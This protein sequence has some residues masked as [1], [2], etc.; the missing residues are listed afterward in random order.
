MRIVGIDPSSTLSGVALCDDQRL[1]DTWVWQ[2][3]A[4]ASPPQNLADYYHWLVRLLLTGQTEPTDSH[5]MKRIADM[6]VVESLS[7]ERNAKVTRIVSHYQAI[8]VLAAKNAGLV[9]IETRA[10]TAR[11][12]V[13]GNGNMPKE[14]VHKE[15]KKMFKDHRFRARSSGG[16]D[17]T[18]A[19]TLALAGPAAAEL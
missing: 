4:K 8:S 12:L 11:R 16:L 2:K 3:D 18:D 10:K 1:I 17:E 6:A 13:L 5:Q 19:V 15:I 14:Q 7:V 9:V